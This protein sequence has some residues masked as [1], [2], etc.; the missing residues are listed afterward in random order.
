MEILHVTA[1]CYPV[2]KAGGLGDVA[3]ALPKYQN[4]LGHIAKLVMPMYRTKFLEQNDWE[5]VH[6]AGTYLGSSWFRY[7]VIK[8]KTNKLGFDLYLIDINGLL[9]REQVY[10]YDDD[11]ERF[12]CFQIAVLHWLSNWQHQPDVLHCHDHHTALIPFMLQNCY[13]I[14]HLRKI[15]TVLTIHNGQYQGWM[16]WDKKS[17]LPSFD[18]WKTGMLEWNNMINPLACGIKCADAVTTVSNSY[19]EELRYSANGLEKLFEYERGKCFGILNGIDNAIWD[20]S[21]DDYLEFNFSIDDAKEGK[22][23]NKEWICTQFKLDATKP[24][25]IFIGRLVG[26]KAAEILPQVISESIVQCKGNVSFMILGSGDKNIEGQL[27]AMQPVL[28]KNFNCYIG[29]NEQLA[30][31]LYAGA[32]FLLMP[33][34]VE[35]CGLNQMYAMRYGTV[36]MVRNTGGLKDTVIDISTPDFKGYGLCFDNATAY[37]VNNAVGRAVGWYY[38][39]PDILDAARKKMM[40]IDH[41]WEQSAGAYT[42][43]YDNRES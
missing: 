37:D 6:E 30:H 1:E 27:Q 42:K 36:P 32:D 12:M 16:G 28:K 8:E 43:V 10:G 18:E 5:V 7:A 26:E 17:Y 35:P 41:S 31:R 9:D 38:D 39:A 22:Q 40:E 14:D 33:S 24:L 3:G 20:P 34:R 11:T 25:I 29:Y 2:A 21:I 19:L 23:K 15:K 13:G 4:Q